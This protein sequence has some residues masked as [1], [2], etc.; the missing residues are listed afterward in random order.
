MCALTSARK[1]RGS[2]TRKFAR[3]VPEHLAGEPAAVPAQEENIGRAIL[4]QEGAAAA[5]V[6]LQ[7]VLSEP[8]LHHPGFQ[9][10]V[11]IGV[12]H[13]RASRERGAPM[14]AGTPRRARTNSP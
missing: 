11:E 6:G 10:P 14:P 13:V 1:S 8:A 12:I 3:C 5:L 2:N 9:E 4:R 7:A